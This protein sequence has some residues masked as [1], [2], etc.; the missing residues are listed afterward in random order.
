MMKSWTTRLLPLS[1][2]LSLLLA[3]GCATQAPKPAAAP[4][5]FSPA[6]IDSTGVLEPPPLA[7]SE[8]DRADLQA[9]L[10]AQSAAHAAGTTARAIGDTVIDCQRVAD[11]LTP[12]AIASGFPDKVPAW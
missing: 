5:Y 12:A 1:L 9:V 10:D 11:V 2:S 6:Q 8:A 3:G 4:V 7:G